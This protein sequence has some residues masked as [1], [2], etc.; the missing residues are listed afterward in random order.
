MNLQEII[1]NWD[2]GFSIAE[3]LESSR[4][5][6]GTETVI[7]AVAAAA[8]V[9]L[10]LLGL[11]IV[12]VW[13]ALFAFAAGFLGGTLAMDMTGI[14]LAYDWIPGIVAGAIL[15]GVAAWLYRFG[16]FLIVWISAGLGCAYFIGPGDATGVL[17]CT[18]AGLAAALFTIKFKEVVTIL[19]TAVFGA[20]T[21]GA[22]AVLLLP[23]RTELIFG[24][25]S[26]VCLVGGIIV[27]LLFESKKRKQESL[28]KADEIRRTHSTE[29]EVERAR[30][31]ME[32]LDSLNED[33][34]VGDSSGESGKYREPGRGFGKDGD[35]E[36]LGDE[37]FEN[38]EFEDEE[39][40]NVDFDNE[41]FDEEEI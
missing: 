25:V 3:I 17:V 1:G 9:L 36:F 38:E 5:L 34:S 14:T 10:C 12:R 40:E 19:F 20:L 31:V 21:V 28:K 33:H 23:E 37:E 32:N 6:S 39:F 16:I 30:A 26:A 13:A 41:N 27:Q 22:A 29:N 24:S 2:I 8:G 11:K 35:L 4:G 15:A 18:A 7:A